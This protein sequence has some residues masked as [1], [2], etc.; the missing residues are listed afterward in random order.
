MVRQ[1]A[2]ERRTENRR[3]APQRGKESLVLS[4]LDRR[5]DVADDREQNADDDAAA[6]ALQSAEDDQLAHAVDRQEREFAGRAAQRRR[7]DEQDR[8]E[9]EKLFAPERSRRQRRTDRGRHI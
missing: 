6:D 2:A 8:A 4:T 1:P 7:D 3:D 5:K 9:H